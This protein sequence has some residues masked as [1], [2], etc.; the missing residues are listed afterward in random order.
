MILVWT[1]IET[2]G[3][4]FS[5]D[6][7]LEISMHA[8]HEDLTPILS[9]DYVVNHLP[10]TLSCMN[11]WCVETHTKNGLINDIQQKRGVSHGELFQ[12]VEKFF[13]SLPGQRFDRYLAGR[14]VGKF[15]ARF[16]FRDFPFMEEQLHYRTVDV[17]VFETTLNALTGEVINFSKS[18]STH[19]ARDDVRD[20]IEQFQWLR[21]RV[22]YRKEV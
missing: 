21:Q 4:D 7:I 13:A 8:T 9:L 15:D 18:P 20:T 14:N 17:S 16:L 10:S 12:E 3:L 2:T 5:N 1:D 11:A 19:R 22:G 6:V